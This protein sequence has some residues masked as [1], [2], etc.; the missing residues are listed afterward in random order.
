MAKKKSTD[1]WIKEKAKEKG[2]PVLQKRGKEKKEVEEKIQKQRKELKEL[3][4]DRKELEQKGRLTKEERRQLKV[5]PDM[6]NLTREEMKSLRKTGKPRSLF[7]PSFDTVMEAREKAGVG[8][9]L[10]EDMTKKE[11]QIYLKE[12]EEHIKD[13]K[14]EKRGILGKLKGEEEVKAH[15]VSII[16]DPVEGRILPRTYEELQEGKY[17][18]LSEETSR[19]EK[20]AEEEAGETAGAVIKTVQE[21]DKSELRRK[22][23]KKMEKLKDKIKK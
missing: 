14:G 10:L 23:E 19:M 12:I 6:I 21:M 13:L 20:K 3:M 15:D 22:I 11:Y 16:R 7:T 4:E 5:L 17:K 2:L 18:S 1:K 8:S 9:K